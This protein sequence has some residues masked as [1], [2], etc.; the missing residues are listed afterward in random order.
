M[1]DFS[2]ALKQVLRFEGGYADDPDDVGGETYQGVSRRFFPR[3]PGWQYLDA[4][5][6]DARFPE[7][8]SSD[9]RLSLAL[10]MFYEEAFWDRFQGGA[11]KSQRIA[12]LLLTAAI[13]L[14]VH[15]AVEFLQRALNALNR[16]QALYPDLLADG[17]CGPKTLRTLNGNVGWGW[18]EELLRSQ[19][20]CH[21]LERCLEKPSQEKFLRGWLSRMA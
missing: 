21:Y 2:T 16:G 4:L 13:H 11:I 8:L 5:K 9:V 6:G 19:V 7:V 14:G 17:Q 18:V 12:E 3:W 20:N 1:A 15:R 10:E